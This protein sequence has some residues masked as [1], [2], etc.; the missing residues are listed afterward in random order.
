[1]KRNTKLLSKRILEI[2]EEFIQDCQLNEFNLREKTYECPG[3][4]GKYL[5]ILF[6]EEALLKKL[7]KME[8]DEKEAY[9]VKFGKE[10]IPKFKLEA[11][12]E[13]SEQLIKIRKAISN[14]KEV[15]RFCEGIYKIVSV[16]GFEIKNAIEYAKL[17][18]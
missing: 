9:I 10:G 17:E 7:Q 15:V 6:E 11:E 14:Q 12:A 13:K 2:N 8:E 4:K 16:F 3:I 18:N 1:M 5:S